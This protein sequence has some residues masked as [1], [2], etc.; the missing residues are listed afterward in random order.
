LINPSGESKTVFVTDGTKERILQR[1]MWS[2]DGR[3]IAVIVLTVAPRSPY[4]NS[5]A[6]IDVTQQNVRG[7]YAFSNDVIH[8]P[9]HFT[10]LDKFRWS[11]DGLKVLISWV[12]AVIISVDTGRVE[13]I[14]SEAIVAEWAPTSD[15][16]Y[17]FEVEGTRKPPRKLGGFYVKRLGQPPVT[18]VD[19][20]RLATAGFT[21]TAPMHGVMTLSPTGRWLALSLGSDKPSESVLRLYDLGRGEP[22]ALER[23]AKIVPTEERI[24]AVEWAPDEST[25]AVLSL[26][27]PDPMGRQPP[28]VRIRLLYPATDEWKVLASWRLIAPMEIEVFTLKSLSWTQ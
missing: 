4:T 28:D 17:Y 5:L 14:S 10:P 24:A 8:L 18:L 13:T 22:P 25:I 16:V 2:P 21:I 12:S 1:P 20:R 19:A 15:A 27:D 7:R 9:F 26:R 23:A 11:P 6:I 3:S